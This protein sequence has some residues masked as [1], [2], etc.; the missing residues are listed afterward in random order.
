[1]FAPPELAPK[2]DLAKCMK[3]CLIHD[4][5]E[6]LVGDIT[7]VDGVPK[8]EKSRRELSTMQFLTR[9]LLH[10]VAG[11]TTGEDILAIW[12]EYEDSK[13]LDSPFVQ[14]TVAGTEA[15]PSFAWKVSEFPL[16]YS[17]APIAPSTSANL[18][19]LLQESLCRKCGS[20]QMSCSQN[21]RSFGA[22]NLT[23]REIKASMV[24]F[25]SRRSSSPT[26]TIDETRVGANYNGRHASLGD[27]D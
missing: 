17:F 11:G 23:S 1:M 10:G 26:N 6:L 15:P 21:E 9:N 18:H 3:M 24:E 16:G 12:Q 2:L 25:L 13:T 22:R 19:T 5:A 7:P 4:M 20:G 27:E 14:Y 8:P